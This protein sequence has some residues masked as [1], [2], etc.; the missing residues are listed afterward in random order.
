MI[1][2]IHRIH[3]HTQLMRL[4]PGR[5]L[6]RL[7]IFQLTSINKLV[8]CNLHRQIGQR[9]S[10]IT[11][12]HHI[13]WHSLLKISTQQDKK[14]PTLLV[15]QILAQTSSTDATKQHGNW[16]NDL[17]PQPNCP[18]ENSNHIIAKSAE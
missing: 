8:P 3:I 13:K 12:S 6:K 5:S 11:K 15:S 9:Q 1:P 17:T 10:Q 18:F 7:P 4:L 2:H 14:R 16:Y